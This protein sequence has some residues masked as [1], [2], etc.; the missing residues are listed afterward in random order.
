MF[1]SMLNNKIIIR[2]DG[3]FCSQIAFYAL[4]YDL[5]QRG[6]EVKFDLGWYKESGK[7]MDGRFDRSFVFDRVF[8]S[9]PFS[10][11]TE[12]ESRHYRI[13][14]PR[15]TTDSEKFI[16]PL[17]IGGY[18]ICRQFLFLKYR[19]TFRKNFQLPSGETPT[20]ILDQIKSAPSC[21]V[22]VRRGDLARSTSTFGSPTSVAYFIKAI[23]IISK[24]EPSCRF[25]FFS[26]EPKWV[27]ENILPALPKS[28][29]CILCDANGSDKGYV[30]LFLMMYCQHFITSI[31][32]LGFYAAALGA[33][34]QSF[35]VMSRRRDAF[36]HGLKNVIYLNDGSHDA[37][38]ETL[39]WKDKSVLWNLAYETPL[40]RRFYYW[41]TR[42]N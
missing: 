4:G 13:F 1:T 36:I 32:S 22:H 5:M 20:P 30:D 31:G 12:K 16:P 11:A 14:H 26:D 9:L 39:T 25:F 37:S 35:T 3:G 2:V 7:D 28:C 23:D 27:A 8:P 29:P 42:R 15:K 34:D 18:P 40:I 6:Y 10:L 21:A 33:S 24:I 38:P 17:Y 41:L 19:Q